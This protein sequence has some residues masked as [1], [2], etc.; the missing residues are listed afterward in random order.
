MTEQIYTRILVPTNFQ[1]YCRDAYR[2]AFAIAIG[3][4]APITL[5]HVLPKLDATEYQGL[6]AERLLHRSGERF[7]VHTASDE[8][9]LIAD[10]H[11]RLKAEVHPE[12]AGAVDLQTEVRIGSVAEEIAGFANNTGVDLIVMAG[13]R[14]RFLPVFNR[15]TEKVARLTPVKVLRVTPPARARVTAAPAKVPE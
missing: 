12:W 6:D 5:L 13:C 15:M 9:T 2:T 1:P 8:P 3:S 10:C 11:A 4:R 7:H 14:P